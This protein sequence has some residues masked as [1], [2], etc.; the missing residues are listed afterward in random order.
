MKVKV[1]NQCILYLNFKNISYT[2][3]KSQKMTKM[4]IKGL[5]VSKRE[6]VSNDIYFKIII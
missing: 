4:L 2:N 3:C 1:K 6:T 5:L